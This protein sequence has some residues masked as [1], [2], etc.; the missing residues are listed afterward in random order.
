MDWLRVVGVGK[1]VMKLV[2]T[3]SATP[4][5]RPDCCKTITNPVVMH[6]LADRLAPRSKTFVI[7]YYDETPAI[8]GFAMMIIRIPHNFDKHERVL[9]QMPKKRPN[10]RGALLTDV[11]SPRAPYLSIAIRYREYDSRR[12]ALRPRGGV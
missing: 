12:P 7:R 2:F 1:I 5:P 3:V 8:W 9:W 10:L 11:D 6:L 4:P